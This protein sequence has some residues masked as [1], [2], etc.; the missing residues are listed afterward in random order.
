MNIHREL[1]IHINRLIHAIQAGDRIDVLEIANILELI[2]R[3]NQKID[4]MSDRLC[5]AYGDA[6]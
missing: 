4:Y 1:N 2:K 3:L 5:E 6:P